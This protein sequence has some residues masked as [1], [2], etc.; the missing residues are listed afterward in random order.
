[1]GGDLGSGDG[2]QQRVHG[3]PRRD[4]YLGQRLVVAH[5]GLQGPIG[6]QPVGL[7]AVVRQT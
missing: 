1:M 7:G 5:L 2:L 6:P 4:A 3:A